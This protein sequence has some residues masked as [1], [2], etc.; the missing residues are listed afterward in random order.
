MQPSR[1]VA[2][3]RVLNPGAGIAG[4]DLT[5]AMNASTTRPVAGEMSAATND[6]IDA[7]IWAGPDPAATPATIA[8]LMDSPIGNPR[9]TTRLGVAASVVAGRKP[10]LSAAR[11]AD[12]R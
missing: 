4:G 7:A 12:I 2:T 11:P 8:A 1:M 5:A 6:A 3:R 10:I 9:S